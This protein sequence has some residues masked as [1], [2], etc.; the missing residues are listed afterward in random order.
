VNKNLQFSCGN[1]PALLATASLR[2]FNGSVNLVLDINGNSRG[3]L[4]ASGRVDQKNNYVFEVIPR[5]ILES[6]AKSLPYWSTGNGDDTMVNLWNPADESQDFVFTLFYTGGHYGYPIHLE[7]RA[8][9]TFNVSEII[10]SGTPDAQGNVTPADVREGSAEISGPQGDNE[11]IL[12]SM[13][14]GTY[15]VRKAICGQIYCQSCNGVT[16]TSVFANPFTVAVNGQT[17]QTFYENWNTG[18][19]YDS[20]SYSTWSSNNTN[21]ATVRT[22]L[23]HGVTPGSTNVNAV[24]NFTEPQSSSYWCEQSQWNCPQFTTVPSG[25]GPGNTVTLTCSPSS[26]TRGSTTTCTVNNPPSGATFSGWKFTDSSNNV[27]NGSG[28]ASSWS[29]TMVMT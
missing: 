17:Q 5:G 25:G 4:A 1:V 9:Q 19:Q 24:D 8:T 27:V 2:N 6:A 12:V 29:G 11:H 21:I 10:R 3:L 22:G 16:S 28:A 13:D 18:A 15:N 7:P 14:A 26:V 20:T 23:V